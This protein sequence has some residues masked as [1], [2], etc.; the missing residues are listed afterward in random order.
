[1]MLIIM[2]DIDNGVGVDISTA[3]S[4]LSCTLSTYSQH[5]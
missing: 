1:M 3:Y 4:S 2:P 5:S